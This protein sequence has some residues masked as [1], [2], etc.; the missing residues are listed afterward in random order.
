MRTV[1]LFYS[2]HTSAIYI[3]Y[4]TRYAIVLQFSL[5]CSP[6]FIFFIFQEYW[7]C[8]A[9]FNLHVAMEKPT[10]L[11]SAARRSKPLRSWRAWCAWLPLLDRASTRF[12]YLW[13]IIIILLFWYY[14]EHVTDISDLFLIVLCV[15]SSKW[16]ALIW[17]LNRRAATL[18]SRSTWR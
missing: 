17:T 9:I 14:W 16:P 4:E 11:D 18:S 13:V 5:L 6:K 15:V 2:P 12:I 8:C 10:C 7:L 3:P 1:P